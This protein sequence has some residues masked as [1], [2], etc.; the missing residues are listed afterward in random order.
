MG[1]RDR[2]SRNPSERSVPDRFQSFNLSIERIDDRYRAEVTDSPVGPRPPV[3]IDAALL[4][5]TE[6]SP[7]GGAKA[8]RDVRR[9]PVDRN[10]LRRLGERLFQA[11]FIDAIGEA[12]RTSVERAR[13]E[14]AGLQIR[15]QLDRAPELATL[16]WEALWDPTARAFVADQADLPVVRALGLAEVP[17]G[18]PLQPPL[19]LLALLPE[20]RGESKLGG[21]EEWQQIRQDLTPQIEQGTVEADQLESPSLP[22][23]GNRIDEGPCHVLHIVAHGDPGD[24]GAGGVL[25]LEDASGELDRVSGFDL[26]RALERRTPPRLV[27]LNACH[28]ARAAVDDAFDGMAQH[29]LSRGVPAVVA[30]RT[31]ISDAAAVSFAGALYHQLATGRTVEGAMVE[32]RRASTT[33]TATSR[34]GSDGRTMSRPW[35]TIRAGRYASAD[36]STTHRQNAPLGVARAGSRRTKSTAA[37]RVS[38]SLES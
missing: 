11:V 27:V 31:A 22:A 21:A 24:P 16:P 29:L 10:D 38:E 19:R 4:E 20:P 17:A 23:L 30:M 18:T 9:R 1:P 14:G 28:G 26:A 25:K 2:S 6:P 32:A 8:T 33:S 34:S 37:I 5:T 12:F 13:N 35:S 15:I 3:A 36:P 7:G